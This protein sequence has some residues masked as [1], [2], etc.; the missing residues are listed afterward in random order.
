MY[1][2]M[3]PQLLTIPLLLLAL[4]LIGVITS[5]PVLLRMLLFLQQH[6]LHTE[7]ALSH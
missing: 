4:L 5:T 6:L 1:V 3:A 7:P 2:R